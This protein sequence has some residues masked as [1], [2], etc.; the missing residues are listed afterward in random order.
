MSASTLLA[1][2]GSETQLAPA[3][4][5]FEGFLSIATRAAKLGIPVLPVKPGQKYPACIT[6]FED[7]ATTDLS[8]IQAWNRQFPMANV[9]GLAR[10]DGFLFLDEDN[11]EAIHALY[12]QQT[13]EDF[14]RTRTTESRPG[15]RQSA[16]KQ[17]DKTRNLLKNT[18]Q[19]KTKDKMMSVRASNYYVLLDGSVHPDT[20]LPYVLVDDSPIVPMRRLHP[21]DHCR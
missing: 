21:I 5:P 12:K 14:P 10:P 19:I 20:G 9:G 13:G 1:P 4:Q 18:A 17:T 11:V 2:A 16:W 15:H 7:L 8:T 6:N 3:S